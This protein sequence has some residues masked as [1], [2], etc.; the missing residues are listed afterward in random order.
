[1]SKKFVNLTNHP[2]NIITPEGIKIIEPSGQIARVNYKIET[3][4]EVEGIPIV[5]IVY[6]D[7]IGLPN[8]QPNTYYIVSSVVKNAVGLKRRDVITLYDVKR[9]DGTP[10]ACGGFRVNG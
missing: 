8:P 9:K 10:Y 1:M 3:I 2:I 5:E 4:D 7:I 6:G